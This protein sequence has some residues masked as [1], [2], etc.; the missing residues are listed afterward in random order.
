M[1]LP[2]IPGVPLGGRLELNGEVEPFELF[3]V[4]SLLTFQILA[5]EIIH[6]E[7]LVCNRVLQ[8]VPDDVEHRVRYS[9]QGT[10][11]AAMQ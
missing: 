9:D 11:F 7:I 4:S 8:Q 6:S 2:K 3:Q 5:L 10:L 1:T